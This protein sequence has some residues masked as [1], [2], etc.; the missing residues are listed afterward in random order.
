MYAKS[1]FESISLFHDE[2]TA[3]RQDLH[4]HP[5]LG[6]QEIRTSTLV[7]NALA[8]LGYTVHRGIGKN[9]RGWGARRQTQ[10]HRTEHRLARRHGRPTYTRTGYAALCFHQP[11]GNACLRPRRSHRCLTGRGAIPGGNTQL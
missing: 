9:R 10:R 8:A 5:E 6:F 4:A 7:A 3:I 11:G 2:L 1:V